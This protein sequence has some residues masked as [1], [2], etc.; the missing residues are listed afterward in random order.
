MYLDLIKMKITKEKD[1]Y[2]KKNIEIN[3]MVVSKTCVYLKKKT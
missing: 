3:Q 1:I 2:I